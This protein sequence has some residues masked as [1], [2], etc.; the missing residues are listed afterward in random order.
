MHKAAPPEDEQKNAG[1]DGGLDYARARRGRVANGCFDFEV[2][3][4]LH[5]THVQQLRS[6]H[7]TERPVK[8][9]RGISHLPS[10]KASTTHE[11]LWK[12][13]CFILPVGEGTL[14]CWHATFMFWY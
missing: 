11:G 5:T 14:W 3:H 13:G 2:G 6:K 7:V 9:L 1:E 8:R 10:T 4:P 12:A